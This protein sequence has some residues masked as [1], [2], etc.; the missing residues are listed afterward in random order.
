MNK[1]S[2]YA[3]MIS[4]LSFSIMISGCQNYSTSHIASLQSNNS[5]AT[6][7]SATTLTLQAWH[8]QNALATGNYE[9]MIDDIHPTRGVRF[10]MYA[11]VSPESDKVFTHAQFA[12][13]L[14]KSN[15]RFN[16]GALDGTG[17]P[18]IISLPQY[19]DTWVDASTFNEST[20]SINE[21]KQ[22]GNMI[23][24]IDKIYQNSDFVEFYHKGTEE[25]AGM[26]WRILRL[27]FD[28]YQGQRYLVAIVNE[29]WT[30]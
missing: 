26:D 5:T 7:N 13:Y 22:S 24:N 20:P 29:Q 4:S 9:D 28:E 21:F 3:L 8:I 14:Q 19:L 27:V 15:I 18:L 10:S 16:W 17:E 11:Y 2:L 1:G 25:Y 12:Q 30:T 23:N 6:N